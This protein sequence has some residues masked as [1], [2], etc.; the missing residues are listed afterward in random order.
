MNNEYFKIECK[1]STKNVLLKG[2][3][4]KRTSRD[5]TFSLY[6]SFVFRGR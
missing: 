1:D 6:F 5:V 2:H 3:I 4:K